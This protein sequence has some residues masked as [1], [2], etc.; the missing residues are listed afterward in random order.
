MGPRIFVL[1]VYSLLALSFLFT[2]GTLVWEFGEAGWL[3]F[4][5][6]DS[7]LFVFFPTLGIVALAAFYLPSVIFLDLYWRYVWFGKIRFIFGFFVVAAASYAIAQVMLENPRRSLWGGAP[8]VLMADQGDPAGCAKKAGPCLRMPLLQALH[9]VRQVSRHRYGLDSFGRDCGGGTPDPYIERSDASKPRRFCFASTPLGDA[10]QLQNDEECC[11]AEARVILALSANYI[12]PATRS[13]VSKVHAAMLPLKVFF[14]I[15]VFII[16]IMLAAHH[17][18]VERH[19]GEL[20]PVMEIG[21]VTGAIS[22]LFFPL[23]S[24][25][26]LQ[27]SE[28]LTGSG[29]RGTF[30]IIVPVISLLFVVWA[31]LIGLFFYRRRANDRTAM[32]ARFTGLF[33]SNVGIIKYNLVI[34]VFVWALG[35]GTTELGLTGLVLASIFAIALMVAAMGASR[36][37]ASL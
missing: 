24:Q 14:L 1:I 13:T 32:L 30:S 20:L 6:M 26:F 29:G 15:V 33:V 2:T 8:E 11:K 23:M 3:D 21:L 35:S 19:Y 16:S 25:A 10:P 7:H 22:M 34:S 5:A 37:Q 27:S 28:A 12:N 36:R 9:N 4:A 31:L 17:R 18:K